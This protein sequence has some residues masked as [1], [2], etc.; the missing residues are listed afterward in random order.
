MKLK[1]YNIVK[2]CLILFIVLFLL[3]FY[4]ENTTQLKITKIK[5]ITN[6]DIEKTL[7]IQG[8]IIQLKNSNET[9]FLIIKDNTSKINAIIFDK[10]K[11]NQNLTYNFTGKIS[12]YNKEIEM[13]IKKVE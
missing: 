12:L 5:N 10:I 13:I 9:T 6:N 11:L 3:I 8:K 1:E 7:K 2:I 4:I